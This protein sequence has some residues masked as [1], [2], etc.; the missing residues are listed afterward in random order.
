MMEWQSDIFEGEKK[1]EKKKMTIT[2]L[3]MNNWHEFLTPHP[4]SRAVL[5]APPVIGIYCLSFSIYGSAPSGNI[6]PPPG[7]MK[8]GPSFFI[9]PWWPFLSA[10]LLYGM[11]SC[12]I[13]M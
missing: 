8:Y 12:H 7:N 4:I 5:K 6:V 13:C 3:N 1:K 11:L 9:H 2:S 10:I